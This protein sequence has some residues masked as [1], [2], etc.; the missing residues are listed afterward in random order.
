MRCPICD[1]DPELSMDMQSPFFSGLSFDIRPNPY[2]D[3]EG[4]VGCNCFGL[5]QDDEEMPE[6]IDDEEV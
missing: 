3:Q 1:F 5:T 6:D 4:N 2:Y